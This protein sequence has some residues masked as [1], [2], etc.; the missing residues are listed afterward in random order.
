MGKH[1]MVFDQ[2]TTGS[3]CILFNKAGQIAGIAQKEHA[4]IYPFPGWVEHDPIE[5]WRNQ[6]E[7]AQ[8]AM[9]QAEI[10]FNQIEAI[11][12]TNQ[13]ETTVVWDRSTGKPV[14]NAIVWQCRRTAYFCDELNGQGLSDFFRKRTGLTLD[15]YFSATKVRWILDN[16]PGAREKANEGKLAFGTID[17]WLIWNM[18]GGRVHATDYSNA[19]RTMLFNINDLHWDDEILKV[20]NIPV[21]LLPS[22][23]PSSFM[24]GEADLRLFGGRLPITGVSGDQQAALYGHGCH[25]SGMAKN[26]YGTG[27]F[28]LMNTGDKPVFSQKGL[29]TTVAWGVNDHVTYALEGSVFVAGAVI[30]W[31][32]DELNIVNESK[33]SE[34]MA[35]SVDDS[36]GVYFV[37]AFVGMGA[38]HWNPHAR[39]TITGLTRGVNRNHLVR[40]ALEAIAYQTKDVLAVMEEESKITHLELKVDGGAANNDF[41]MQFQADIIDI[42]IERPA[43]SEITAWGAAGL[44]GM[45]CG[46]FSGVDSKVVKIF[47]P[48]MDEK[49]RIK[50]LRG[51]Q[52]AVGTALFWSEYGET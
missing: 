14:Y 26:T 28:L 7:I 22:V 16:V 4:Q 45:Y 6:L 29:L 5:I 17:T 2:G 27:G 44:A 43:I 12:I 40:A 23:Q 21:S 41:L 47:R 20:L 52:R 13:R 42:P 39:G 10:G 11:G 36:N 19:S 38:P 3:R 1:I 46:F 34:K 49:R 30:Q 50:L 15:P 48:C 18:T 37:P 51:W 35:L 32:R 25:T 31:L 24:Y 33:D 8:A 9:N